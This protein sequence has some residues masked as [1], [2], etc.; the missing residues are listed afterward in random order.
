MKEEIWSEMRKLGPPSPTQKKR[1][2]LFRIL[3][4]VKYMLRLTLLN[5]YT[6]DLKLPRLETRRR[7]CTLLFNV[8]LVVAIRYK[9]EIRGTIFEK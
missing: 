4:N 7:Y 5:I 9:V 6:L 8:V 1:V 3:N 2:K